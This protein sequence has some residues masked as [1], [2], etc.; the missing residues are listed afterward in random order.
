[1]NAGDL[2]LQWYRGRYGN[3][4]LHAFSWATRY[5]GTKRLLTSRDRRCAVG[6][7]WLNATWFRPGNVI[8]GARG[9]IYLGRL[10]WF[11]HAFL[12]LMPRGDL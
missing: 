8:S 12:Y 1:M 6:Q 10:P 7:R 2:K 11:P 9:M 4:K 5:I 3:A